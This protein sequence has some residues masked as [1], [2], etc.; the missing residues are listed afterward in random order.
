M[1]LRVLVKFVRFH[2][3]WLAVCYFK[4]ARKTIELSAD[5]ETIFLSIG[6]PGEQLDGQAGRQPGRQA[7]AET[8]LLAWWRRH[9]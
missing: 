7:N 6:Q 9:R 1:N 4:L 3:Q 2:F 5:F 8:S